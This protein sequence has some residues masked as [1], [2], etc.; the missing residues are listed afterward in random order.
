L[1]EWLI[2][3]GIGETRAVQ[4]SGGMIAAARIEWPGR[5][6]S[7]QVEDATLVSRQAGSSRATVRFASGE[8]ALAAQLPRDASEGAPLRMEVTRAALAEKGRHKLAQ[9]R[10][11]T[12]APCPAPTLSERLVSE[13]HDARIVHI[14]PP[15]DWD[16]LIAEAMLGEVMFAGGQLVISPTPAMTLI[17]IDGTLP[18]RLLALAAVPAL[19]AALARFDLAG[20]IGIDFPTLA[21]KA[22]RRA[23]DAALTA[24]LGHWPHEQ[25][26]MNGFGFV[27][28][29]ARLERSSLIHRF[30]A[31]PAG[32]AARMLLRRAE[33]V[34]E[35]GDL[36]LTL[37]PALRAAITPDWEADLA[38]RTGRS[39]RWHINP[40]LAPDA[41]FAQACAA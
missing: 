21:D 11:T 18:P 30:A 36:L 26:A 41:A 39:L 23:V 4:L 16:E 5:L 6:A 12:K 22:D 13:G 35:P 10:P 27:Q 34:R 40:A 29:V 7:G 19:A 37:H 15:C 32:A 1:A 38:R 9:A 24:S 20:S 14:F 33:G 31:D 25:T 8:Q 28:M 17:D 2:E 3:L